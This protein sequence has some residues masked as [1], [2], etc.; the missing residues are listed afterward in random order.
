MESA[1][2]SYCTL[3]EQVCHDVGLRLGAVGDVLG[4]SVPVER[5]RF[6]VHTVVS[7]AL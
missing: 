7:L 5:C 6:E 3:I 1:V 2:G 4:H